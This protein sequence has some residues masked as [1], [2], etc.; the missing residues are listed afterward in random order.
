MRSA[1]PPTFKWGSAYARSR[2]FSLRLF[3]LFKI[4]LTS[5]QILLT[6][7][8]SIPIVVLIALAILAYFVF[9]K[10]EVWT[11]FVYPNADDLTAHR[12]IGEF[13]SLE[14]C[15]SAVLNTISH[16]GWENAD[17]ECGLNCEP[18]EYGINICKETAE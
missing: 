16:N 14:A 5:N 17:Y 8:K 15:R 9:F 6:A 12:A 4:R 13:P 3:I 18:S 2:I 10:G 1:S 11:G 7:D